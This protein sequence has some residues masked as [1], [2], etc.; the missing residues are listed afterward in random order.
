MSLPSLEHFNF[1]EYDSFYEPAEDTY[2]LVDALQADKDF[3]RGTV[4]PQLCLE[5][6]CVERGDLACLPIEYLAVRVSL[7]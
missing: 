3:L 2:L 4:R 5:I 6:G 7:L 1:R